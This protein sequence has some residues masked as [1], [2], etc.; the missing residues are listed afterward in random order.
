MKFILYKQRAHLW[1]KDSDTRENSFVLKHT[2]EKG[3]CSH[4]YKKSLP[5]LQFI[6]L[7]PNFYFHLYECCHRSKRKKV[8]EKADV[9]QYLLE[10][11]VHWNG[12]SVDEPFPMGD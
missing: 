3:L 7:K 1:E 6:Y 2:A 9:N 12:V 10:G 8:R 5:S 11:D 4:S